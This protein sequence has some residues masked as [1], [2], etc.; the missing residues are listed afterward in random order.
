MNIQLSP[1]IRTGAI[2]FTLLIILVGCSEDAGVKIKDLGKTLE[3]QVENVIDKDNPYVLSV[4][5]GYLTDNPDQLFGET[6]E[7]FFGSPTWKYFEAESGEDI[8]E[9]TGYMMYAETEVKARFQFIVLEDET[10]EISALSFNDV[11]QNKLITD[12]VLNVVFNLEEFNNVTDSVTDP[13]T[14]PITEEK[15]VDERSIN[16]ERANP[17]LKSIMLVEEFNDEERSLYLESEDEYV[18]SEIL[19]K[20]DLVNIAIIWDSVPPYFRF[21]VWESLDLEVKREAFATMNQIDQTDFINLCNMEEYDFMYQL[22]GYMSPYDN[23]YR[24]E[25]DEMFFVFGKG[26]L[27]EDFL[28]ETKQLSIDDET[29]YQLAYCLNLGVICFEAKSDPILDRQ[30]VIEYYSYQDIARKET[31]HQYDPVEKLDYIYSVDK[32]LWKLVEPQYIRINEFYKKMTELGIEFWENDTGFTLLEEI[33]P[34][35]GES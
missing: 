13:V 29:A 31:H 23:D 32:Q 21:D 17:Y 24:F 33:V 35:K 4:K 14:D 19:N 25:D 26:I 7:D 2:L 22:F 18:I 9:F 16:W 1:L 3:D 11:P 6:F 12:S 34:K 20:A 15:L 10:F 8:V 28:V 27:Y 5:G 30:K